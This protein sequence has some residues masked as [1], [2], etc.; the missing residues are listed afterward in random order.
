MNTWIYIGGFIACKGITFV[1]VCNKISW[2]KSIIAFSIVNYIFYYI[3][4]DRA[5]YTALAIVSFVLIFRYLYWHGIVKFYYLFLH[6]V[7]FCI[8]LTYLY[9]MYHDIVWLSY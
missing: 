6:Q 7:L 3:F 8:L 2:I 4:H 5:V 1:Q 9:L